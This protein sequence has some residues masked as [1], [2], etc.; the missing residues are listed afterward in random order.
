MPMW[1]IGPAEELKAARLHC[2]S[3]ND[4]SYV[5]VFH[6]ERFFLLDNLCPHKAAALCEGEVIGN[7]IH[8]PWHRAKFDITTGK[9]LSPLAGSGVTRYPL[10]VVDGHLQVNFD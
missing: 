8:C 3:Y 10:E 2:L 9:G 4:H 6:Q 7:E 5:L 1:Q